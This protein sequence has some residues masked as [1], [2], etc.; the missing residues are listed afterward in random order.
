MPLKI[1]ILEDNHD[2]Q[3]GMQAWLNDRLYMYEHV[4]F[5]EA[6][7]CIQWLK[8]NLAETLLIS[9]DHDLDLKPSGDGRWLDPGTGRDVVDYLAG[10]PASCPIIIHSTNTNAVAGMESELTA[11][12]WRVVKVL[13]YGDLAW[14]SESWWPNVKQELRLPRTNPIATSAPQANCQAAGS[15]AVAPSMIGE[16]GRKIDIPPSHQLG[17]S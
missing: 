3:A 7:P 6:A 8:A 14:I 9:L 5:D 10:Q 11:A 15:L 2:R 16:G 13:P 17:G 4:F 1:A 12:G